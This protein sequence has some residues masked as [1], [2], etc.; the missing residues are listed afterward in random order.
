M[1]KINPNKRIQRQRTE[2]ELRKAL[3]VVP[4]SI[5]VDD[6]HAVLKD[7]IEEL[8]DAR[9]LLESVRSFVQVVGPKLQR[10]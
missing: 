1:T 2:T 3:E 8:M 4:T 10:R 9:L 6:A 7:C 5:D